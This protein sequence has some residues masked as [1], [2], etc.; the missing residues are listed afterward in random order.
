MPS[1]RLSRMT[2]PVIP[3]VGTM[4]RSDLAKALSVKESTLVA[5][6]RRGLPVM[7]PGRKTRL[8]DM[9]KVTE[10]LRNQQAA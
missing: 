9:E 10:W 1:L 5:W 8:Y 6:E 7:K 4:T 2:A 3:P